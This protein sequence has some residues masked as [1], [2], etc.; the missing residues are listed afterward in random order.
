MDGEGP[1]A[2]PRP[3]LGAVPRIFD[4][5]EVAV[6]GPTQVAAR[7]A[8]DPLVDQR[9]ALA[10]LK[11]LASELEVLNA[12][13]ASDRP[14]PAPAGPVLLSGSAEFLAFYRELLAALCEHAAKGGSAIGAATVAKKVALGLGVD[15]EGIPLP[16]L[17]RAELQEAEWRRGR[18][19]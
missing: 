18:R 7:A 15:V 10:K 8:A 4:P 14:A 9:A 5:S 16:R 12:A 1:A 19:H 13:A 6:A 3:P 2:V 11:E 17:T